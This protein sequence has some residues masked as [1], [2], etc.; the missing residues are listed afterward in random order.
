[1]IN[2]EELLK[3]INSHEN[4]PEA[5]REML[6]EWEHYGYQEGFREGHIDGIGAGY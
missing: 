2:Y 4:P 6:E 5:L 3:S 1:M